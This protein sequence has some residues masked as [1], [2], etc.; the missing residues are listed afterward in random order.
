MPVSSQEVS[1]PRISIGPSLKRSGLSLRKIMREPHDIILDLIAN[2]GSRM[3]PLAWWQRATGLTLGNELR[4]L[5][6]TLLLTWGLIAQ[7]QAQAPDL[8]HLSLSAADA[9]LA[10]KNRELQTA[11]RAVEAAQEIGRAHV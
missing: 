5:L 6:I 9:L 8:A 3:P 10:Q 11:R 7:A 2:G 1:I 4:L